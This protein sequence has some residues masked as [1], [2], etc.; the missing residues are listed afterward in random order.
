[1]HYRL[2]TTFVLLAACGAKPQRDTEVPQQHV[3]TSVGPVAD[4][5]ALGRKLYNIKGCVNCHT[6]DGT[7]RLG[8]SWLGS[9]GTEVQVAD[10]STR[11]VDAS[12]I[13]ESIRNPQAFARSG[14]PPAMPSFD[15]Y[16]TPNE[17]EA[18]VAFI[19]QLQTR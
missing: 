6:L 18:L 14:F 1:M 17:I 8:P 7:R 16:L 10:G 11:Q 12:Y 4:A 19:E 9:W 5:A 15:R 2:M 13:R 3:S